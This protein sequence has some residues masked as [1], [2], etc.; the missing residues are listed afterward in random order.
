MK[1]EVTTLKLNSKEAQSV[2]DRLS[3]VYRVV[4]PVEK[5]GQGRFSDT[6]IVA[7][8]EVRGFDQI[9]FQKK[10]FFSAKSELFPIRETLFTMDKGAVR[11]QD[12]AVKP[13]IIFLRSCD[14][15]AVQVTDMHF[16]KD[17]ARK[18]CYYTRRRE[19]A[20]FFLLECPHSFE[21][22]YCASLG[23]NRTEDY[24]VFIRRTDE[25][26]EALLKDAQMK[27]FFP[28]GADRIEEPRFAERNHRETAIPGDIP[29][30]VFGNDMWKEY[31]QRCIACGRC[32]TCCPTCACFSVHDVLNKDSSHIERRRIW[33]SCHVGKFSL[34]AGGHDFRGESADR[35]RYKTLHKIRDFNRRN[36][37]QMCVGC[38]RCDDACPEYISMFKCID[39]INRVIKD[40]K[41]N[42]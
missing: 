42:G 4:A 15:H 11:E 14:I 29:A 30:S 36:G 27:E 13:A 28:H 26:Y 21:N 23:T 6:G 39:K 2:F 12:S 19:K 9:E 8:D 33:S 34:L 41:A 1:A 7:Y 22:C 38:G 35:M 40:I 20:K 17:S 18:D 16:L 32:T 31:S 25:G 5:E 3:Q 10:T 37:R 24:A